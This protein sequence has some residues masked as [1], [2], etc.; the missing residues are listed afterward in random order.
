VILAGVMFEFLK[1]KGSI[2]YQANS[3]RLYPEAI[4]LDREPSGNK[5][6]WPCGIAARFQAI[7]ALRSI[8]DWLP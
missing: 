2:I 6:G 4:L 5:S 7:L 1:N 3:A 8:S